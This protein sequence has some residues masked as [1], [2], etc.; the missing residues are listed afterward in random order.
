MR[1]WMITACVLAGCFHGPVRLNDVKAQKRYAAHDEW[2]KRLLGGDYEL[3]A[4]AAWEAKLDPMLIGLAFDEARKAAQKSLHAFSED[5]KTDR[6]IL[7]KNVVDAY[8]VEVAIACL[9]GPARATAEVAIE[10]VTEASEHI[11]D[12]EPLYLLL[13][14]DCPIT[15]ESR[16]EIITTA[17]DEDKDAY[18]L[19][20][21]L[22]SNWNVLDK[23]EFVGY[24]LE[25][26]ECSPGL[27]AASR[28]GWPITYVAQL[29]RKSDCEK[30][31]FDSKDWSFSQ[32][33]LRTLFFEAVRFRKYHLAYEFNTLAK[34]GESG[35]QYLAQKL[36]EQKD[37]YQAEALFV[38][39]PNLRPLVYGHALSLGRARF[40]GMQSKDI[41]WQE[42]AYEKLLEEG[43][44]EDAAEVAEYG[45]SETLRSTGIL[46][47]FHA[48]LAAD[49]IIDA[50]YLWKRYP[51][52]VPEK[53]YKKAERAWMKA[54]PE[55]DRFSR[56]R[57]LPRKKKS[58]ECAAA[59]PDEW[60]VTKCDD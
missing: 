42:R 57:R 7:E 53:E 44:F 60:T 34:G 4:L 5:Q 22:S 47:A 26:S 6:E 46:R 9:Y 12:T 27:K 55:D 39:R 19:E 48:A 1:A 43:K 59:K 17:V 56:S 14:Y 28:L 21:A 8:R 49:D 30:E 11:T 37:E 58:A 51:K 29:L 16:F 50:R 38:L 54:H 33:E 41:F 2:K 13:D 24:Y 25:R 18:A 23:L 32:T 15:R 52:I 40:V 3:A 36:L 35:K 45:I 10:D 20:M 31:T